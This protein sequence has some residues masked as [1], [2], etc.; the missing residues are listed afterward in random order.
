MS[1]HSSGKAHTLLS[2]R[3]MFENGEKVAC[4][5]AYDYTSAMLIDRAGIDI[6]LIGDSLGMVM[7]GYETTLPVTVDEVIYHAKAVKRGV[8]KAFLVA[9]MPFGSYQASLEEGISNACRIVKEGGVQAVKVEGG[10]E[11]APLVEALTKIGIPVMG[12]IGLKPQSVHAMGGYIIQGRDGHNSLLEDAG[13]LQLSGAFSVVLEG[14]TSK[15]AKKLTESL[16]ILTIGI[17]AGSECGGQI[18]VYHDIFG[19]FSGF[20]PK[21]VKRYA[22]VGDIIEGAT[23]EYIK[24]VK[25]GCFPKEEHSF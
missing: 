5:T 17:G 13:A 10:R 14:V 21:F 1:V 24:D 3:K 11:V 9:D 4:L 12:H 22:E 19:L 6:I 25:E 8:K 23:R 7:N 2:I 20:T 18:L 16:S 15:V